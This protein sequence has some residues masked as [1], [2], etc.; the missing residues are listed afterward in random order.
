MLSD[1][2]FFLPGPA[3]SEGKR[4]AYKSSDPSSIQQ[5]GD[6][7]FAPWQKNVRLRFIQTSLAKTEGAIY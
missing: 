4:Q 1:K 3:S 5:A 6:N 2:S 7:C